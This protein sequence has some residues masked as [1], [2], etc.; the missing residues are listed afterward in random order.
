MSAMAMRLASVMARERS[1]R[2]SAMPRPAIYSPGL[3]YASSMQNVRSTCSPL[4]ILGCVGSCAAGAGGTAACLLLPQDMQRNMAA[5]RNPDEMV[6]LNE[7]LSAL[8][9]AIVFS[10]VIAFQFC[11]PAASPIGQ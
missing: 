5:N 9:E 10:G 3:S 7:T 1:G 11:V 8:W 4:A 2:S 6:L